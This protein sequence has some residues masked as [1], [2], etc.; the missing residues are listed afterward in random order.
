MIPLNQK[1]SVNYCLRIVSTLF[2]IFKYKRTRIEINQEKNIII[3]RLLTD[4]LKF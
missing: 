3:E 1:L 2:L 4:N